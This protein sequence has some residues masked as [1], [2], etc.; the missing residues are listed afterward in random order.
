MSQFENYQELKD[1]FS[2]IHKKL[3]VKKYNFCYIYSDLRFFASSMKINIE[4][5]RF[6][7]S[8]ISILE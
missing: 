3:N 8:I 2:E 4:K 1:Y 6:C 5:D 7:E